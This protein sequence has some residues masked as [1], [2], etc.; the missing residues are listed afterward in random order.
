MTFV[1]TD[2]VMFLEDWIDNHP[3]SLNRVFTSEERA[4]AGHGV[5]E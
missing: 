2:A 3:G 1:R 5:T 4:V